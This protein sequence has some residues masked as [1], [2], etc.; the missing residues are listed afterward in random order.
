MKYR[1]TL[2]ALALA[3]GALTT[4]A[5]AVE[6][7]VAYAY[8]AL[9][10]VTMERMMPEF[11][12]AHPDIDVKFRATYENY[13]DGTNTILRESVAGDLPDVT[14]QGL[15]RQAMLV[16]K[17]IARSLEPFIAAE[18]NFAKDGYHAAMLELG[19][20]N[21]EVHGLPYSV[22][23][24]VGYYNMDALRK[25][26]ITELPK[27]WDEVIDNC[28]KLM[29]AG[30]KTPMWWGWSVTGNWFFQAL[31]WSQ[32]EPI[33]KDGKVNFGG[34]AGLAALEQMKSLFRECDMPNL[35]AGDAGV[36]FNS[37]EVAMYFWSTSAVGAIERAKGD[38]ELKTGKYPGMG[39]TPLGLPA[40]GNSVMMVST[41]EDPAEIQAAWQFVKFATSGVGASLV[42]ETTGYIP[43]NKAAND[44]L[45]DFYA[46]NPN[47]YTAVE[48]SGLLRDWIAYPGDNGLAITQV[49]YD[50]MESIVTGDSDDMV[51]LQA[52]LVE[53]VNDLLP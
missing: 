9:F 22:S 53:E 3:T 51:A 23:L 34:E 13:E 49:L 11:K 40:G 20:F 12:K 2:S 7:E 17:G 16:E 37:G 46:N 27:T 1:N 10:D 32:G 39:Q 42:A 26:G 48:Q 29:K 44:L 31:M 47:K 28:H 19:T 24:P 6:I 38:F 52:E 41:S 21:G 50:G 30:Y 33:L 4:T 15:N 43:P 36:P 8:S 5:H 18:A 25:A 45:T 35:S 14:F